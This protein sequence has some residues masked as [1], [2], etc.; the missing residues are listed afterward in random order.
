MDTD[1]GREGA[2]IYANGSNFLNFLT[3]IRSDLAELSRSWWNK[4]EGGRR[5][6]S[7][8][9]WQRSDSSRIPPADSLGLAWIDL[10]ESGLGSRIRENLTGANGVGLLG[11]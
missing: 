5:R 2:G 10:Q 6:R 3:P 11:E 4:A 9:G 8:V 1:W 7:E